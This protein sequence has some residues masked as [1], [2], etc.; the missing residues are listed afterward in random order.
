MLVLGLCLCYALGYFVHQ[1]ELCPCT[2]LFPSA[3]I[4]YPGLR[5]PYE[6]LLGCRKGA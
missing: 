5:S 6:G 2:C 1:V 4:S 3:W